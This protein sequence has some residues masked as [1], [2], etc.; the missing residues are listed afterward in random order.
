M[1]FWVEIFVPSMVAKTAI[2]QR[3]CIVVQKVR[4]IA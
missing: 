2:S 4:E 1:H 3:E